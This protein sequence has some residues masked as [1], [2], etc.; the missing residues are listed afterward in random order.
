MRN[1]VILLL[2]AASAALG[3]TG[4]ARRTPDIP[5]S[6][7]VGR[8]VQQH[9]DGYT[10]SDTCQS[11]HPSQFDSWHASYHRTMTQVA[12]PQTAIP[13]FDGQ[14]IADVQ[15]KPM[16]LRERGTQLW[17][18]FDD[19]DSAE[20]LERRPR[21]EREVTMITGS[22]NQQIF[23]YATGHDRVL[24]QLPAA[25]LVQERRWIPRRMAV[26]HPPSQLPLS[27]TGH[28]NSTCIACHATHGK[29]QFDTPFGSQPIQVQSVQTTAA[30]FGIACESCHGPGEAHVRANRNPLR[31][32]QLHFTGA[33]D[34]TIVQPARLDSAR[35][36]QVCAQCHSVWEFYDAEGERVANAAGLP[37]RP[38]D[39][40][41]DS[42]FVAQPTQNIESPTMKALLADDS[43]F[44]RDAFWAD[45]IVRVSGREYNG[46][47][48]SPCYRNATSTDRKLSCLS[49][50]AL[51]K[52][53]DD[54][55]TLAEWADDQLS[56]VKADPKNP[57]G[58]ALAKD[59]AACLQCHGPLR[60]NVSAHSHH[61]ADSPG[62]VCYNC[63][64]P[65][66][67]Y[68]LLKTIRSH[69][70]VNPT[71][72]E[73]VDAGRPNACNLCHLDKTLT[74][75][76]DALQRW[77]GTAPVSLGADEQ[78]VAASILWLLTGDAGQRAIVAQAMAWPP[79][80]RASGVDWIAPYL[81]QLL[82]DPYDAVRLGAARS[83]K[84]LP[85]FATAS[86]DVAGPPAARRQAQL[87]TMSTWDQVRVRPGRASP[88][89]LMTPGGDVDIPGVLALLKQRNN[90]AMLL[91]E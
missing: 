45:G 67:T 49:C 9:A 52:D 63:H 7:V 10:S 51:H 34:T 43:R 17:A 72:R 57:S 26:L 86:F 33:A 5:E 69:T 14:T 27:E 75:T 58:D 3:V 54:A 15:G 65:Y 73:S 30:E 84:S 89:L 2:I 83:L 50:H 48:D 24:G 1:P 41:S 37:F 71:V 61:A 53:N 88:E 42:R 91:R 59:N 13:D 36:S 80:Q 11:C 40:I 70:I 55:R 87:R 78:G 35:T 62:S 46:L 12:T 77:Y 68:G 20:P 66:T 79:A 32:Y 25:Y 74:W 6:N 21:I 85:G 82:D 29:P 38:G 47:I 18:E 16:I 44:I 22:H 60:A 39:R 28:W 90:K 19:P 64:M 81:A 76:G 56:V 4:V 8:P 23:W 31:R